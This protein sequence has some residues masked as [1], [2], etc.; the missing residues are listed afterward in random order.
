MEESKI[1]K[2]GEWLL[3]F[4]EVQSLYNI[5]AFEQDGTNVL[6]P[7][8]TSYRRNISDKRDVTDF[9]EAALKPYASVYEE[10]QLNCYKAFAANEN[11]FNVLKYSEVESI[12]NRINEQDE[13]GNFP[14]IGEKV[15]SVECYPFQPQL[16]GVDPDTGLACYYVTIRITYVNRLKGRIV[17]WQI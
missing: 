16:R 15:V 4:P 3:Q 7:A 1:K 12:I 10:F 14:D 5:S 2:I 11:E 17:E 13:K 8:G 9:Y 6:L